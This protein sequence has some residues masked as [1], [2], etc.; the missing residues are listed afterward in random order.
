MTVNI[1]NETQEQREARRARLGWTVS[2][3][4]AAI[5]VDPSRIR[6]LLIE[7]KSIS[8]VKFGKMWAISNNEAMRFIDQYKR[9][10]LG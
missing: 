7:G 10:N 1:D 9:D 3:I 5:G 6:Q 2:E 8:G 4:A